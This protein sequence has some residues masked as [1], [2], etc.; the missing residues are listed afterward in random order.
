MRLDARLRRLEQQAERRLQRRHAHGNQEGRCAACDGERRFVRLWSR[1]EP[2]PDVCPVCRWPQVIRI[3]DVET[4]LPSVRREW[5][6]PGDAHEA[7]HEHDGPD[8]DGVP[9]QD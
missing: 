8:L 5:R 7:P 2:D 1:E 9:P 3:V 4:P 6:E